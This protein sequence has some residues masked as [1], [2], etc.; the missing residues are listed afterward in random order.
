M[1]SL[2]DVTELLPKCFVPRSAL[3]P[4]FIICS[5]LNKH[6]SMAVSSYFK[7]SSKLE[8]QSAAKTR[9]SN[10]MSELVATS[11]PFIV[12]VFFNWLRFTT[13]PFSRN[14]AKK[15]CHHAPSGGQFQP[16][17]KLQDLRHSFLPIL[18]LLSKIL[19][20]SYRQT[21]QN[22]HLLWANSES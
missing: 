17:S 5:S 3:L 19:V 7:L 13:F 21:P 12:L 22:Q 16:K 1:L 10:I 20:L 11:F 8:S 15:S 9:R 6:N 2:T 18:A 14:L 4:F